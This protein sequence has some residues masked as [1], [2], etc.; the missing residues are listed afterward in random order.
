MLEGTRKANNA[1]KS[2]N[3]QQLTVDCSYRMQH[4]QAAP[5]A[6]VR[7][8]YPVARCRCRKPALHCYPQHPRRAPFIRLNRDLARHRQGGAFV[9][10]LTGAILPRSANGMLHL[11]YCCQGMAC[12][13]ASG[14]LVDALTRRSAAAVVPTWRF[15]TAQGISL[16]EYAFYEIRV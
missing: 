10:A 3:I 14:Q 9:S 1:L 6:G 16:S 12:P 4:R 5:R 8:T 15:R 11:G 2:L 13:K 7:A